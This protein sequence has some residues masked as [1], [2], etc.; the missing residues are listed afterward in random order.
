MRPLWAIPQA[1]FPMRL[2]PALPSVKR[3]PRDPKYRHVLAIFRVSLPAS[4]ITLRRHAHR[5]TCSP[6]HRGSSLRLSSKMEGQDLLRTSWDFT[7]EIERSSGL[8]FIE[9]CHRCDA[10]PP[11]VPAMTIEFI[12]CQ[13]CASVAVPK[14]A[15]RRRNRKVALDDG[16][17]RA[18]AVRL[19]WRVRRQRGIRKLRGF[20]L[21]DGKPQGVAGKCS[22]GHTDS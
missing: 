8:L 21:W 17:R 19:Q 12:R 5:R 1:G 2:E 20:V 15:Y 9:L 22:G 4:L 14:G 16:I 10:P 13:N 7:R 6:C 11:E 18:S 3:L